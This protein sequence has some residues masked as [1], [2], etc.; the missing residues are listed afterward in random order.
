MRLAYHLGT[1]LHT[2]SSNDG[3]TLRR[4]CERVLCRCTEFVGDRG[5]PLIEALQKDVGVMDVYLGKGSTYL[6]RPWITTRLI[7]PF[8]FQN[9]FLIGSA[10]FQ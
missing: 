8:D 1:K 7:G 9:A 10:P 3:C 5:G 2:Y 4:L 6:S